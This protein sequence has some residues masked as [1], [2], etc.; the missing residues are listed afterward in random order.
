MKHP[1]LPGLLGVAALALALLPA[2]AQSPADDDLAFARAQHLRRGINTSLWFA[3]S[4]NDYSV[5]HLRTFTTLDDIALIHRL[6]FDHIRLS[7][8]PAPLTA[9]DA[10]AFLAELDTVVAKATSEHLAVVL[11]I[12]PE[13]PYKQALLHGTES[14]ANFTALWQTLATHFASTDPSFLFFEIMNEP[15]Q[16]DPYRWLGIQTHVAQAIRAIA[17][18]HTIIASGA[19][20]SGMEDLL[21]LSPIG[22]DN[23]IYTFHDYEPFAFTHQGATW[24]MPEVRPLRGIPYPSTPENIEPLLSQEPNPESRIWLE[25]YGAAHWNSDHIDRTIALVDDWSKLHHLPVYCGEF[26]VHKP[27]APPADR[28]RWIHDMRV[29]L[30]ARNIGWAMWDYQANFGLVT[31]DNGETIPDSQLLDALG[32][33][34]LAQHQT[35]P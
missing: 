17:P 25:K 27:F 14:V 12:H 9:P 11:D 35:E 31:K 34:V 16:T 30:E 2:A 32:L 6:G 18:R 29:A 33:G 5:Q 1:R 15:E 10:P 26:G 22:L 20:W 28:A 13:S 8:D 24:T 3:Q 23:V 19:H 21:Q 7:V 4:A